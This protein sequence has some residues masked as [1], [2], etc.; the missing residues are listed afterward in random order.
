MSVVNTSTFLVSFY[1]SS[2]KPNPK[3]RLSI[4]ALYSN[5]TS[6]GFQI[7]KARVHY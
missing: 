5:N 4:D 2:A 6:N 7:T 3:N 1:L